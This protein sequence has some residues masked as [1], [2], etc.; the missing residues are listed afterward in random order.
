MKHDKFLKY[1]KLILESQK[2]EDED[3]EMDARVE[4]VNDDDEDFEIYSR[5][6]R[7]PSNI[8]DDDLDGHFKFMSKHYFADEVAAINKLNRLLNKAGAP[9]IRFDHGKS[10]FQGEELEQF[11]DGVTSLLINLNYDQRSAFTIGMSN[12]SFDYGD[13]VKKI[14]DFIES[15]KDEYPDFCDR[16][17]RLFHPIRSD[18]IKINQ[19][20]EREFLRELMFLKDE[21]IIKSNEVIY[22]I[23]E[24]FIRNLKRK[25]S[26]E[27]QKQ[28][29]LIQ[30]EAKAIEYQ[31]DKEEVIDIVKEYAKEYNAKASKAHDERELRSRRE[32]RELFRKEYPEIYKKIKHTR[33][34]SDMPEER[35]YIGNT[36]YS[37]MRNEGVKDVENEIKKYRKIV[38][39]IDKKWYEK[40]K[41][42]WVDTANIIKILNGNLN[43]SHYIDDL[44]RLMKVMDKDDREEVKQ[45]IEQEKLFTDPELDK[46]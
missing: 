37:L 1:L 17:E 36:V 39:D 20:F 15:N 33:E 18:E 29:T 14:N 10:R 2:N 34:F 24:S 41:S 32:G 38:S 8:A 16:L 35:W 9:R 6:G 21:P 12:H 22:A 4:D 40:I 11:I 28:L 31:V 42:D 26:G 7:L 5:T 30:K 25:N 27:F 46:L 13:L 3:D 44:I 45:Y 43:D 19:L 23:I